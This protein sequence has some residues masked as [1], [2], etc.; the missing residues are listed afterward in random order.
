MYASAL[1]YTV[2]LET[3]IRSPSSLGRG[4]GSCLAPSNLTLA[5]CPCL[6]MGCGGHQG[7]LQCRAA[8]Q[9]SP[10]AELKSQLGDCEQQPNELYLHQLKQY[11]QNKNCLNVKGEPTLVSHI[12]SKQYIIRYPSLES[13]RM[14]NLWK[15]IKTVIDSKF[16]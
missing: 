10:C 9:V 5:P 8:L 13:K 6:L 15:Y 1:R 12:V 16:I 4:L 7:S 3:T 11:N 14:L 2:T